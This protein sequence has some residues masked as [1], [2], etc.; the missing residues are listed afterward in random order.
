MREC[1][2]LFPQRMFTCPWTG[3]ATAR[4]SLQFRP[5]A[6]TPDQEFQ[7]AAKHQDRGLSARRRRRAK[8]EVV[9][10]PG[11][12]WRC[13]AA[14]EL[15]QPHD[16]RDQPRRRRSR[17]RRPNCRASSRRDREAPALVI[18]QVGTNAV[19]RRRRVRFRSGD[20]RH[21]DGAASVGGA[22]HRCRD[23]GFAICSRRCGRGEAG[24]IRTISWRGSRAW[25]KMPV[26]T[27]FAALT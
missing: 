23:H 13:S 25:L 5:S 24:I 22:L 1:D 12:S 2:E 6:R 19:F 14:G 20:R 11:K 26:S 16:R 10:L 9:A 8:G 7:H 21:C 4:R 3:L 18:W 15:P 17:K 27:S